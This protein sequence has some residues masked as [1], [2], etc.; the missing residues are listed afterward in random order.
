MKDG[1]REAYA[2]CCS[3]SF[4]IW[5]VIPPNNP[6]LSARSWKGGEWVFTPN[7]ELVFNLACGL[8]VVITYLCWTYRFVL[9]VAVWHLD[10]MM[11]RSETWHSTFWLYRCSS[12]AS[13]Y[14]MASTPPPSNLRSEGVFIHRLSLGYCSS[15]P[16]CPRL[17]RL[18]SR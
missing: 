1:R 17:D 13:L 14:L 18:D 7:N 11:E 9:V 12:E 3:I 6:L 4:L 16:T 15:G 8:V 5:S 10:V 2:L